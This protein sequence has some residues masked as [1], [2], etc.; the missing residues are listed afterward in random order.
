VADVLMFLKDTQHGFENLDATVEF[1]SYMNNA[2]DILNNRSK[3]SIKP[4]NKPISDETIT[5]YKEFTNAF[6]SY[7]EGLTFV[8][9]KND[10]PIITNV[11]QS[12][13]KTGFFGLVLDLK[14]SINLYEH[15]IQEQHI[16]YLLTYKLSQD[17]IET[18]F[19]AI[20]SRG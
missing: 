17:H 12:N 19:S 5:K 8:E 15:F 1:V 9:H 11:L 13:R 2:F 3:F 7:V 20:R 18:T 4:Y 6:S 16:K 14:N 10:Q